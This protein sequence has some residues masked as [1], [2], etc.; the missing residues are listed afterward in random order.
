MRWT[1]LCDTPTSLAVSS[2]LCPARRGT[3]IS[4]LLTMSIILC[5]AAPV[6]H[7]NRGSPTSD[8]APGW[9]EFPE[10]VRS[11]FLEPAPAVRCAVL[12]R[13]RG[14]VSAP[15]QLAAAL[16][17]SRVP[18][19]TGIAWHPRGTLPSAVPCSRDSAES[20]RRLGRRRRLRRIASAAGD[21]HSLAPT[22]DVAV[23]CAVLARFRGIVSAP[24]QLA[25]ALVASRG[26]PETGIAWHPRGGLASAVGRARPIP[27][28]RVGASASGGG[29]VA[30]RGRPETGIAWHP[31]GGLASAVGCAV[32]A[33]LRGIVSAP[34]QAAAASSHREGAVN[35]HNLAPTWGVAVRC[36]VLARFRGIVSAP[37]QAAAALVASRGRPETGIAWHP[38]GTL[39]SAVPCSPDSAESCQRLGSWQRVRCIARAAGDWHSLAPTWDVAVRCAVLARF[40]GIVSAPRQAAAR[41]L[42]REGGRRLA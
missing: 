8:D 28:N 12:A 41:S 23:R 2:R 26:R 24:R 29:F 30:S 18:P 5:L 31:R 16:V 25:A 36:A 6:G 39:P 13:F 40:R 17:A 4:C 32:L 42:H 3:W 15:R 7:G 19:E 37:R 9:S 22:W 33:R 21:W 10:S 20:C 11:E 1:L 34:R 38:R 14:I 35:W 27:R